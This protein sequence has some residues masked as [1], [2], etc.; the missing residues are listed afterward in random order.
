MKDSTIFSEVEMDAHVIAYTCYSTFYDIVANFR[1]FQ[2]LI[3]LVNLKTR[4]KQSFYLIRS[5]SRRLVPFNKVALEK[6]ERLLVV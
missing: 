4:E 5:F 3:K 2:H 6:K 1:E